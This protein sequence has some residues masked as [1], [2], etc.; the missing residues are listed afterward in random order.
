MA[1]SVRILRILTN[2]NFI[3]PLGIVLGFLVGPDTVIFKDATPYIIGF[4]LAISISSYRFS[5]FIPVVGNFGPIAVCTFLNYFVYGTI[6]LV[7]AYLFVPDPLVFTGFV[8]VVATPPAIAIIPFTI[9]L[10][11]DARYSITG[12]FGGNLFGIILTP[13]I[14]NLFTGESLV[15]P[16]DL[17]LILVKILIVPIILSRFFRRKKILKVV[18][19]YRGNVVDWGYFLVSFTVIGLNRDLIINNPE[20]SI[21]PFL[22]LFFMMFVIGELYK[23]FIKKRIYDKEIIISTN[24]MLTVKNAGFS[25]VVAITLFDDIKY[26]L[27][28][29]L[30]SI[31]IPLHYL[32]QSNLLNQKNGSNIA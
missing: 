8:I 21:I 20:I 31:L 13:L 7:L 24:L 18:E 30:L 16:L 11:G 15:G 27:P 19:K 28:S 32:F 14:F 2:R 5:S 23:F 3:F 12:V 22:I 1:F 25:A 4:I 6:V 26:A 29:A 17:L 10:G 9:N